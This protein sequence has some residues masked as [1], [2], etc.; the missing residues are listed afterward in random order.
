VSAVLASQF[1]ALAALAA[2]LLFDERLARV[3][4]AG[5]AVIAVGV[6]TLTALQA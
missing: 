2:F 6:A 1:A 5:I 4:L 3:Q